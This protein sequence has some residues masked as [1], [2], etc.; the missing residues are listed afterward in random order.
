M[1]WA[2]LLLTLFP[3][4][5]WTAVPLDFILSDV[6]SLIIKQ[7]SAHHRDPM[8]DGLINTIAST[9]SYKG[10][11]FWM[12]RR[13]FWGNHLYN[14]VLGPKLSGFLPSYL[15]STFVEFERRLMQSPRLCLLTCYWPLTPKKTPQY[16]FRQSSAQTFHFLRQRLGRFVVWSLQQIQHLVVVDEEMKSPSSFEWAIFSAFPLSLIR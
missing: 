8:I 4:P 3:S 15:H 9:M 11:G 1:H 14:R 10:F 12:P 5:T 16:H 6:I 2:N 7:R 13:S